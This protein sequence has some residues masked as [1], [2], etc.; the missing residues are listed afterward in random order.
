MRS[1]AP[2][3]PPAALSVRGETR[4]DVSVACDHAEHCGGCPLIG[5]SY[6]RQLE[7]KRER[8]SRSAT[9]YPSLARV[10]TEPVAPAEPITEYRTRAKLIVAR[11]GKIGLFAKGGGH[12]VVDVPGCRVLSPSL[13]RVAA[14]LRRLL[15]DGEREG[16]ALAPF[17]ATESGC[18][19]A[20]DLRE[21]FDGERCRVLVTFV[22]HRDRLRSVEA[23]R[24]AA[25]ELI[26]SDS[27]VVGVACNIREGESARVLGSETI[28]LAGVNST[29]DRVGASTHMAT[30]GS[31]VQVHRGQAAR[32]HALLAD[33]F[34]LPPKGSS[35]PKVLDLYGGSGA[36]ALA[37][38]MRGAR[39]RM[40]ESFGPAVAQARA[41][42]DNA[43]VL[44]DLECGEVASTLRAMAQRGERF[45]AVVVNPPRRGTSPD[46]RESLARLKPAAIAY[47]SCDPDTLTR[48]LDHFARLGYEATVLQPVD[49]IPLTEEVETVVVLR[50]ARVS[51]P[52]I[53]FE[54][55]QVVIVNKAPHEPTVPQG[56]YGGSL[57]ARVRLLA[58]AE[59]AR[60]AFVLEADTSG[61]VVFPRRAMDAG[62]WLDALSAPS[63]RAVFVAAVRG[64]ARRKG[65][66]PSSGA[67]EARQ[68]VHYRRIAIEA[69]HS[70]LQIS[71]AL[72]GGLRLGNRLS[73]LGHPV[74]GDHRHGHAPTNRFFEE[75]HTLDRSFV[76]LTRLV[77]DHPDSG[78]RTTVDAALPGDLR[79][80]LGRMGAAWSGGLVDLDCS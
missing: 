12:H 43:G 70:I 14:T 48:D 74:L 32:V 60:P 37:L 59:N 38:A 2:L 58:G 72:G 51:P 62:K 65:T 27:D 31:F 50:Q 21:V 68:P 17:D 25:Q 6:A 16:G 39:V 11:G 18:L 22:A 69:G 15:A 44:L 77:F 47:V 66:L 53:S 36:I 80:V 3:A 49:M 34:G 28:H 1:P 52:R 63:S 7:S 19:Q 56:E 40:V 20:I 45:D 33:A 4:F 67:K 64:I 46:A 10:R 35:Q 13:G 9:L 41:A 71:T 54:D 5:L 61:L 42:A 78:A 76:H 55:R 29:S 79:T 24:R 73:A 30:F 26:E 75:K 57:F 8:V 23:L